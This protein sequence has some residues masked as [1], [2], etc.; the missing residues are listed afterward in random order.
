MGFGGSG[1]GSGSIASSSDV[2]LNVPTNND[3]LTYDSS[4]SKWKNAVSAGG[5]GAVSSVAGKTGAVTLDKSDVGLANVSNTSDANK[6]VSSATQ[7]A[8]D[9]KVSNTALTNTWGVMPKLYWTGSSWPARTV[10][11]GYSGPVTWDSATDQSAT[12]P[13]ASI[14]GDRW[15]RRVN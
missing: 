6:P 7:T 5:G 3:V 13:S 4:T 2:A 11:S 10:P 12:A 8:L 9:A 15:L 14:A 1:G